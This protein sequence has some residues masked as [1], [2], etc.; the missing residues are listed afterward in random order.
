[1]VFSE[2]LLFVM[3]SAPVD[4]QWSAAHSRA[5]SELS[6][7]LHIYEMLER[8]DAA[9]EVIRQDIFAPFVKKVRSFILFYSN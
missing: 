9:G 4:Q 3:A 2:A 8:W 7:S 1:M 5:I 6:E